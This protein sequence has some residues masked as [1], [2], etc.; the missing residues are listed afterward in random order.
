MTNEELKY[1]VKLD[2]AML[3]AE[4]TAQALTTINAYDGIPN[5]LSNINM[6]IA[7]IASALS[8]VLNIDVFDVHQCYEARARKADE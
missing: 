8:Q 3:Y 7:C 6:G 4:R 5:A 1:M 2:E